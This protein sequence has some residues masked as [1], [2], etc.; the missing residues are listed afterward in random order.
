MILKEKEK[1]ILEL[2]R[3]AKRVSKDKKRS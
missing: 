2:K 3:Y 1:F